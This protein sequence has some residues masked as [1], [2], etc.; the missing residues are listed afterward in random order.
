MSEVTCIQPIAII[1]HI[2]HVTQDV[3]CKFVGSEDT[4]GSRQ[5]GAAELSEMMSVAGAQAQPRPNCFV[6]ESNSDEL[7]NASARLTKISIPVP[8]L[9]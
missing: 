2:V 6:K 8:Q 3:L 7:V 9:L 4:S 1:D 5:S